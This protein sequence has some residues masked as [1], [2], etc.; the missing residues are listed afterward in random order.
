[1]A[2][3]RMFN[4]FVFQSC[5]TSEMARKVLEAKGVAHFWDRVVEHANKTGTDFR[6][7]LGDGDRGATYGDQQDDFDGNDILMKD[8]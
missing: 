4:S 5:A 8:A 7:H 1:M 3:K 2:P 6:F